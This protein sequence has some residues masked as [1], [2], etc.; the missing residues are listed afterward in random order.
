MGCHG[1]GA[2]RPLQTAT[3]VDALRTVVQPA[4]EAPQ[5][6]AR[7]LV[8]DARSGL[9]SASIDRLSPERTLRFYWGDRCPRPWRP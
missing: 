5:V 1:L 3:F 8:H 9:L 7:C 2:A 4:L 6:V